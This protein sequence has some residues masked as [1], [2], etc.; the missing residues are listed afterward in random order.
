MRMRR[1][2]RL[3]FENPAIRNEKMF[4]FNQQRAADLYF[5]RKLAEA[6]AAKAA[7]TAK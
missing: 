4:E 2:D 5:A 7:V 6:K 1:I 3:A